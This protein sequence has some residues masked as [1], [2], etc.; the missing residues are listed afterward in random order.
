M[1]FRSYCIAII[2]AVA[3]AATS[4]LAAA[5]AQSSSTVRGSPAA[6]ET[7]QHRDL[8]GAIGRYLVQLTE[9]NDGAF[10]LADHPEPQA[11]RLREREL[12]GKGNAF[13]K[14]R[15][16][17][18]GSKRNA[19]FE[20]P[21]GIILEMEGLTAEDEASLA[22]GDL[23]Q[24][25]VESTFTMAMLDGQKI[26]VHGK[27]T[28]GPLTQAKRQAVSSPLLFPLLCFLLKV[29]KKLPITFASI[30]FRLS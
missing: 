1:L 19:A 30:N 11:R 29:R 28:E 23:I 17:E 24:L 7:I 14:D 3:V 13:G 18:M 2:A 21:N 12:Q 16:G 26:N 6:S 10:Q 20:L 9:Y 22:S 8:A 15:N 4:H 27:P 25:P 5:A